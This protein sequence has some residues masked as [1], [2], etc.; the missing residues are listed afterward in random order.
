MEKA[1]RLGEAVFRNL[2]INIIT[3]VH[4]I[5]TYNS[6][7]RRPYFM[8]HIGKKTAFS[9]VCFFKF[10]LLFSARFLFPVINPS[11]ELDKRAKC[12]RNKHKTYKCMYIYIFTGSNPFHIYFIIISKQVTGCKTCNR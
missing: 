1:Y 10:N 7:N 5:K 3:Q 12:Q 11:L 4:F 8:A 9:L 6:I 2:I